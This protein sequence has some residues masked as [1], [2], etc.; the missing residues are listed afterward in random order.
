MSNASTL[1]YQLRPNKS[2]D[3]ELF[4]YF[5]SRLEGYL[6][7]Q[8]YLYIGLGGPFLEDFRLVHSR[9]GITK[10]VC[11]E[12]D[13]LVHKRQLF[14]RPISS[15]KCIYSS[16]EDYL[17]KTKFD[18]PIILWLDYTTFEHRM[19]IDCFCDQI[20]SVP[21][22]SILKITLNANPA[23]FKK[24]NETGE[25]L[26]KHRLT[27]LRKNL[28]EY[29]PS[30]FPLEY[31]VNHKFGL[32]LLQILKMAI[33]RSVEG[34]MDR[35]VICALTT[36]YADGQPMVTATIF[37]A[38]PTDK[39][40]EKIIKKWPFYSNF[41]KPH[42]LDLPVLSTLER[43]FIKSKKYPKRSLKYTF[44]ESTLK[45]D[46]IQTYLKFYRVY[47]HFSRVDL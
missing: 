7:L 45:K 14:N 27:E 17:E 42:V 6:P 1:P 9:I 30:E 4:L 10:M 44:P 2:V 24:T 12:S 43:L 3:R 25:P 32:G 20:I 5:L 29:V 36:H 13:E 8:K 35:K 15:I 46:P 31:L 26:H 16:M 34:Y 28:A 21:V 39:Y 18:K 11:I 47:P 23:N 41:D 33:S 22:G 40:V 19:Q 38:H 37:I